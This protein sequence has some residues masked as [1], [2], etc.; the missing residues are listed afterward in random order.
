MKEL[1]MLGL[2]KDLSLYRLHIVIYFLHRHAGILCDCFTGK[3]L[4]EEIIFNMG[5]I[6]CLNI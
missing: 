1:S 3:L 2:C 6:I 4:K 5:F